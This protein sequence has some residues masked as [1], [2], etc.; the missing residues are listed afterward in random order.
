MLNWRRL[1]TGDLG[2]NAC[3][4]RQEVGPLQIH[5]LVAPRWL[6]KRK[7]FETISASA[8]CFRSGLTA[9]HWTNSIKSKSLSHQRCWT[10]ALT[11]LGP[12]TSAS[13]L[14]PCPS[15]CGSG[16]GGDGGGLCPGPQPGPSRAV[17]GRTPTG[18]PPGSAAAS[19]RMPSVG[20]D[21]GQRSASRERERGGEAWGG[22]VERRGERAGF[23]QTT[24]TGSPKY[25]QHTKD[26]TSG[27]QSSGVLTRSSSGTRARND[28]E[29]WTQAGDTARALTVSEL[30][31]LVREQVSLL[32][33]TEEVG[34][35]HWPLRHFFLCNF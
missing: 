33:N 13:C 5:I 6:L 18:R 22:Q 10:A 7:P 31:R 24:C 17:P 30:T 26:T 12:G 23:S 34:C 21:W 25:P 29:E 35:W 19:A 4:Q 9:F 8:S 1:E 3:L 11:Q 14:C 15:V 32:G 27:R 20:W 2:H 28:R 16:G